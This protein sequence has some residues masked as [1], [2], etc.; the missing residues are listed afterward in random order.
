MLL[1]QLMRTLGSDKFF[2]ELIEDYPCNNKVELRAKL[3]QHQI[4]QRTL[5]KVI[6]GR[7]KQQYAKEYRKECW[8]NKKEQVKQQRETQAEQCSNI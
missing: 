8:Q 5:N 7:T 6:A 3:G 4:E 1:F 2:I